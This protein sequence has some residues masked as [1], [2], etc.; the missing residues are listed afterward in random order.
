MDRGALSWFH[1]SLLTH[2]GEVILNIEQKFSLKFHLNQNEN[3]KGNLG[4]LLV[5][6]ES[7]Q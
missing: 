1:T 6:L 7:S 5:L 2:G 4:M 3:L